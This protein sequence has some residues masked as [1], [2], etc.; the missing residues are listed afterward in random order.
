[1]TVPVNDI[2]YNIEKFL[3]IGPNG[4]GGVLY[5]YRV[6]Q[7]G[8]SYSI[9]FDPVPGMYFQIDERSWTYNEE[10][11]FG[12]LRHICGHIRNTERISIKPRIFVKIGNDKARAD[13]PLT[14]FEH[15]G[16]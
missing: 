8:P 11:S 7:K 4:T 15:F 10:E 6:G 5:E 9:L 16:E 1:M 14:W 3:G 2:A 12:T 13:I